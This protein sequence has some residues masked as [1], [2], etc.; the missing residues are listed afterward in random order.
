MP[1]LLPSGGDDVENSDFPLFRIEMKEMI[2]KR[3]RIKKWLA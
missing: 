1:F 3:K 2:T